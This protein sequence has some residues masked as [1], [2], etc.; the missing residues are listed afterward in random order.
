VAVAARPGA[1]RPREGLEVLRGARLFAAGAGLAA[2]SAGCGDRG[3]GPEPL[4]PLDTAVVRVVITGPA[5]L[6][7]GSS[8]HFT[9]RAYSAEDRLLVDRAIAWAS[10]DT[11]VVRTTADGRATG[12][13]EGHASIVATSGGVS[14]TAPLLVYAPAVAPVWVQRAS[15]PRERREM[16]AA[17]LGGRI[18]LAGGFGDD[19]VVL[20]SHEIY[21]PAADAWAPGPPLPSPRHHHGTAALDGKLYVVGGYATLGS[22]WGNTATLFVFDPDAG[23]W[24]VR[25]SLPAPRAAAAVAAHGGRLFVFGGGVGSSETASTLIYDPATDR[26]S[27]GAPMPTAREHVS[28]AVIGGEIFVAGGRRLNGPNVG[29]L[30]VYSPATD[31][32]RVLPA[33]GQ[34]RS[35]HGVAAAG[36]RLYVIGGEALGSPNTEFASVEEFDPQRNAWRA[37]PPLPAARS[38]LAAVG[39]GDAVHVLGGSSFADHLRLM[40]AE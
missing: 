29:V 20:T 28:A 32:W 18:H 12:L 37:M 16:P 24:S 2:A 7:V 5:E 31:S 10:S 27:A 6:Q 3:V 4:I 22:D 13:A 19:R 17:V 36:G 38:G 14:A 40:V 34:P 9:A 39:L 11:T 30:E 33:M 8:A 25:A 1:R 23:Q 35:G 26:W 21:D 15:L